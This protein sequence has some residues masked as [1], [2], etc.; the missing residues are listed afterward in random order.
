L[1][2]ALVVLD[3]ARV[4][5]QQWSAWR[6]ISAAQC[7]DHRVGGRRRWRHPEHDTLPERRLLPAAL[8]SWVP[9]QPHSYSFLFFRPR[10]PTERCQSGRRAGLLALTGRAAWVPAPLLPQSD[11]LR[12]RNILCICTSLILGGVFWSNDATDYNKVTAIIILL[13]E[14]PTLK[15]YYEEAQQ[16]VYSNSK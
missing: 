10:L 12:G 6:A 8:S 5:D 9:R 2:F 16:W 15:Y 1:A 4:D 7:D 3:L 11:G 14:S 13:W